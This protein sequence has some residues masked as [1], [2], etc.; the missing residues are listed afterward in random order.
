[1]N[2][3]MSV[4]KIGSKLEIGKI[5]VGIKFK[6][7]GSV[8]VALII[9]PTISTI[10]NYAINKM[11]ILEGNFAVLI[12]TLINLIVVSAII[13][14]QL[15]IIV[16]RPLNQIIRITENMDVNSKVEVKSYDEMGI[17]ARN[18]N[19][20]LSVIKD[21]VHETNTASKTV[22]SKSQ[23]MNTM[24]KNIL[25]SSYEI[26]HTFEE[27]DTGVMSQAKNT[28]NAMLTVEEM[29]HLVSVEQD[30]LTILYNS[31][32]KIDT[33]KNEGTDLLKKLVFDTRES[34]ESTKIV[35]GIIKNTNNSVS[36]IRKASEM[37]GQISDQTN[38][39]ALN[40]AIEAAR[41]GEHGR[42]FSVVAEEIRKLAE[43]SSRFTTEIDNIINDLIEKSSHAVEKMEKVERIVDSQTKSV[44][45][46]NKKFDSISTAINEMQIEFN[47]LKESGRDMVLKKNEVIDLMKGL[48][49]ISE[50]TTIDIKE[51]SLNISQQMELV[52]SISISTEELI[53]L[54]QDL[55][56][57]LKKFNVS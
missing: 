31:T 5:R 20:F 48:S 35:S 25:S 38:L 19:D 53:Q 26:G 16:L 13:L 24:A 28:N 27:I 45:D 6:I 4:G 52:S 23:E 10:L 50:Q 12:S 34:S 18:L 21:T 22:E 43:Q 14:F 49:E 39:L 7:L 17:L 57:T 2:Q 33:L 54:E 42:G 46:T 40:A 8:L 56:Y 41:A 44:D 11:H 32:S 29:G 30:R 37:I 15:N 36:N 3:I 51:A 55:L 9:S 47:A 1:M